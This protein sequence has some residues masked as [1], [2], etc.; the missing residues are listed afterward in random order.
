MKKRDLV[1][2]IMPVYMVQDFVEKAV[3]SVENQTYDNI[4]LLCIDDAS[5]DGSYDICKRL[6]KK[7]ENI[8]LLKHFISGKEATINLGQETTRN[9]GLEVASG[10]Y[11]LF[12]DSDDTL[13][14]ETIKKW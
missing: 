5:S 12:L 10:K 4:E 8:I 11:C 13:S 1:S 9:L 14:P 3:L 7:Y 6:A 2:V